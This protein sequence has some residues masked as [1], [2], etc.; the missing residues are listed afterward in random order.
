MDR[1]IKASLPEAW[2]DDLGNKQV[3]IRG[4]GGVGKTV[5][6]LQMAY[7]AFDRAGI[8]EWRTSAFSVR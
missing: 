1:I 8:A 3:V 4:R 6:L 7:R 2:L 5:I